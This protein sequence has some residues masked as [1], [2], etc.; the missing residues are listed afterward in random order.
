MAIFIVSCAE[1]ESNT[2]EPV[3]KPVERKDVQNLLYFG[4]T[5]Y[6]QFFVNTDYIAGVSSL[7]SNSLSDHR[8]ITK[9]SDDKSE[10]KSERIKPRIYANGIEIGNR[11]K[12]NIEQSVLSD[13]CYGKDVSF[14]FKRDKGLKSG[15][16]GEDTVTMYIP[17]LV[18]ITS[19]L[20]EQK[21]DLYPMCY[22][23]NFILRW[24]K[25]LKNENGL[26]V[27]V[28]WTGAMYI[29]GRQENIFVRNV[30]IIPDDNG[31]VVLNEKLFEGIPDM[32]IAH[33]TIM[34][35][36]IDL[37]MVGDYSYNVFGES[38]TELSIILVKD[39]ERYY[40]ME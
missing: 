26:V 37:I 18:S 22:N 3:D 39:L 11:D 38:H 15:E 27:S 4:E 16:N 12:S 9:V 2:T 20:I 19:P 36:N 8:I 23:K 6:S 31:E 24:N 13:N 17:E 30:D 1:R 5:N 28:E 40:S 35:G 25:D 29:G 34:R 33:I 32:S 21:E 7:K 14:V 10:Q